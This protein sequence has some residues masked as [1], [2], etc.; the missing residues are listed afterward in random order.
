MIA[1]QSIV[2]PTDFSEASAGA[3]A[4]ALKI[5][6]AAKAT[7]TV[8]HVAGSHDMNEWDHFPHVR[9]TLADWGLMDA[10]E[11]PEAIARNLGMTVRKVEMVPQAPLEGI[12]HYLRTHAADLIVLATEGRE[13]V[14]R[15]LRGSVAEALARHTHAPTLFVPSKVRGFVD[16]RRG[17]VRLRH[18]LIPV[19]HEPKPTAAIDT[20]M[21]FARLIAG[22]DA[23][24]RLLHAGHAAPAV[25]HGDTHRRTPVGLR[26]GDAV[27]AIIDVANDWPADLIGMPTAG[28]HGFLDALRG[29]TTERVLRRAP[30]PLLAVPAAR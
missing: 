14:A 27:D 18:V 20:I 13:G 29:S 28:H 2:H 8:L 7:L 25:K 5:A 19:D 22:I 16:E 26:K 6:L 10:D 4:H 3:F 11:P 30:C 12:V 17:E 15:W 24:E 9:R 21:G 23:E 1:I